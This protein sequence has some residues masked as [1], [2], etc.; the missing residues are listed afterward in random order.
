MHLAG[1]IFVNWVEIH[2]FQGVGRLCTTTLLTFFLTLGAL[3]E[4]GV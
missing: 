4:E 3:L 1:F 2:K